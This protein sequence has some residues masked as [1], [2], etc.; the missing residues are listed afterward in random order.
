M[1]AIV[2]A[3][4]LRISTKH[5]VEVCNLIRGKSTEKAKFLLNEVMQFKKAVP[6]K[7]Y[8][9]DLSH[10]PGIA[11]G[12][13]PIKTCNEILKIIQSGEKNAQ[14]KGLSSNLI[15]SHIALKI[16]RE[17]ALKQEQQILKLEYRYF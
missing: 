16:L 10:K 11:A 8:L 2:N 9:R 13:F 14:N 5:S 3:K 4:N 1:E 7:K 15:I 17:R 6:Y 12:R